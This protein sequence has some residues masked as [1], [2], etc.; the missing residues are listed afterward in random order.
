MLSDSMRTAF[1]ADVSVTV[2]SPLCV[3]FALCLCI[4]GVFRSRNASQFREHTMD[5]MHG[6]RAFPN[7]GGYALHVGC[8][9]VT[10]GEDARER[11]LQKLWRTPQ[12]PSRR[13][14]FAGI[15]I[16]AGYYESLAV[17]GQSSFEPGRG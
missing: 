15:E 14:Q 12:R 11:R 8:A 6:D 13:L 17:E 1:V 4:S 10:H 3:S 9:R 16:T 2:V 7:R 5:E